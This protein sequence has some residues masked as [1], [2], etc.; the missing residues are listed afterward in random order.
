MHSPV[1]Y[2]MHIFSRG[3]VRKCMSHF[4]IFSLN[5][6]QVPGRAQDEKHKNKNY[7]RGD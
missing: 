3:H 6:G 7:D 4:Q 5:S 2:Q 1:F